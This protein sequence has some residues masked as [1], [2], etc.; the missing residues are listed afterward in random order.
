MS[1]IPSICVYLR[2]IT[3]KPIV[4]KNTS[5]LLFFLA[6]C[7]TALAQ[8]TAKVPE[9][10][11]AIKLNKDEAVKLSTLNTE[12]YQIEGGEVMRARKGWEIFI[13]TQAKAFVFRKTGTSTKVKDA[14]SLDFAEYYDGLFRVF[15]YCPPKSSGSCKITIESISNDQIMRCEG[16]CTCNSFCIIEL[17]TSP[18]EILH[19]SMGWQQFPIW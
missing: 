15:C 8:K 5:L 9:I 1:P 14:A 19:P 10:V 18:R 2:L 11:Q 3:P 16:S 12:A 4:M 13:D 17:P 6:I 7:F